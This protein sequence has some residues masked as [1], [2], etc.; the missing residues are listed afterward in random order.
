MSF[1]ILEDRPEEKDK[2]T[3]QT[4]YLTKWLK[5]K[6]PSFMDSLIT[7]TMVGWYFFFSGLAI[8]FKRPVPKWWVEMGTKLKA[9]K[10]SE[11]VQKEVDKP[12]TPTKPNRFKIVDLETNK[13]FSRPFIKTN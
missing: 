4:E 1:P 12:L 2:V 3:K 5:E 11:V 10:I 7:L 9:Q 13:P 8:L 6:T